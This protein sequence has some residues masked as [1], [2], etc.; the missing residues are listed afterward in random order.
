VQQ[1]RGAPTVSLGGTVVPYKEV[2]LAAQVPG[3]VKYLAGIEVTRSRRALC[4]S[5]SM[6]PS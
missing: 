5:L 2:T 6:T 1:S 4:W 3:R